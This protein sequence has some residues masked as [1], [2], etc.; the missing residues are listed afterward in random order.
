[1]RHWAVSSATA[2]AGGFL[3]INQ[4]AFAPNHAVWIGMGVAIAATASSLGVT[5]VAV[6]RNNALSLLKPGSVSS[7]T[8]PPGMWSGHQPVG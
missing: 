2:M 4:F 8:V 3:A 1:M 6:V 5:V 7:V